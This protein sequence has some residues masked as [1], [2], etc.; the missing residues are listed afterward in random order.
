MAGTI[1]R[2]K[3]VYLCSGFGQGLSKLE[4]L[5][6]ALLEAGIGDL[7]LI[8]VTSILPPKFK[9]VQEMPANIRGCTVPCIIS[10]A[11]G[12]KGDTIS[13]AMVIARTYR[14][15]GSEDIGLVAEAHALGPENVA[16]EMAK[17]E[18]RRM[19]QRR[20]L[21]LK[22]VKVASAS[23]IVEEVYGCAVACAVML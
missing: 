7:S 6:N 21:R 11:F 8:T 1:I 18:I 22:I 23:G 2:P 19:A 12:V 20:G 17:E 9:V 5:D 4:A 14:E 16:I 13:A 3:S 10:K 15:D